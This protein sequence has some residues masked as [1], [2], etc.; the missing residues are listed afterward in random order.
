ML[1][2]LKNFAPDR[3]VNTHC[4]GC[5]W[6]VKCQRLLANVITPNWTVCLWVIFKSLHPFFF[7]YLAKRH[8]HG[9]NVNFRGMSF[10]AESEEVGELEWSLFT[11]SESKYLFNWIQ[12]VIWRLL[13]SITR[14]FFAARSPYFSFTAHICCISGS[15]RKLSERPAAYATVTWSRRE[16]LPPVKLKIVFEPTSQMTRGSDESQTA[17]VRR[18]KA[19]GEAPSLAEMHDK[20]CE[21]KQWH[22]V[23]ATRWEMPP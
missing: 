16:L 22:I 2:E 12:K 4:K 15:D 9:G 18:A 19:W 17:D 21:R 20:R 23:V 10:C 3:H 11:F 7:S 6:L 13:Y 14:N 8:W 5:A 1:Y